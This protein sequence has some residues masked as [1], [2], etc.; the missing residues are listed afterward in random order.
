M[1]ILRWPDFVV[2]INLNFVTFTLVLKFNFLK[3]FLSETCKHLVVV[4][5]RIS[6][7]VLCF[8]L[9]VVFNSSNFILDFDFKISFINFVLDLIFLC[10]GLELESFLGNQRFIFSLNSEKCGIS[11]LLNFFPER[12]S[13]LS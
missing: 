11:L 6:E 4:D 10:L 8:N 12:L 1:F 9:N 2:T 13:I 3:D 5:L 7:F